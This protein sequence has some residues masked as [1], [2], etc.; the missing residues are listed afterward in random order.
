MIR[1]G[2]W[3]E[4]TVEEATRLL[5]PDPDVLALARFGSLFHTQTPLDM[6]SDLDLLLIVANQALAR[7]YPGVDWLSPLGRLYVY[8]QPAGKS[9]T[10][11]ICFEDMRRIDFVIMTAANLEALEDTPAIPFAAGM[12]VLFSRSP[13]VTHL[14]TRPPASSVFTPFA[15]DQFATVVNH[16]WFKATLAVYKLVRNDLLIALHL[17]LDLIRDCCVMGMVL[18]DR[19]SGTNHHHT[20]G[21]GNDLVARLHVTGAPYTPTGILRIVEQSA[22]EFDRLATEW[23]ESYHAKRQPLLAWIQ[24][25]RG[26]VTDG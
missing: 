2:L 21:I 19:E 5:E 11:R 4:D 6:W 24:V 17:A 3:Q 20:G 12:H 15:P 16:F 25:A 10:T 23:S 26:Y 14:L 13:H 7:F 18:R 1:Q 9:K 22:I 8:D